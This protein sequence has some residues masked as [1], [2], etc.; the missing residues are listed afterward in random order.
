MTLD[1]VAEVPSTFSLLFDNLYPATVRIDPCEGAAAWLFSDL[2]VLG[3]FYPDAQTD[4]TANFDVLVP[5]EMG[6]FDALAFL[7]NTP[8]TSS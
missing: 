1:V 2:G 7:R 3:T 6:K 4:S 5:L 8:L